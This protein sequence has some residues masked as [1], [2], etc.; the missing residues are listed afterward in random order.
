MF[1]YKLWKS[2]SL[3]L[4]WGLFRLQAIYLRDFSSLHKCHEILALMTIST[5]NIQQNE[6]H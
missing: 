3:S 5:F 2:V 6:Y 4:K 1:A